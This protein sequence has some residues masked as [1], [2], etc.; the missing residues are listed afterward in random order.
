MTGDVSIVED[1]VDR[2]RRG[3]TPPWAWLILGAAAGCGIGVLTFGPNQ[4]PLS[5]ETG[6]APELTIEAPTDDDQA[7]G[8]GE[9]VDGFPD[10]LVAVVESEVAEFEH[11]MWPVQGEQI[12]RMLTNFSTGTATFDEYGRHM[13]VGAPAG[14]SEQWTLRVG[15]P[16]R[17]RDVASDVSGFAWHDGLPS[18][19]SYTK[20][21]DGRWQLWTFGM[22]KEP[23]LVSGD[24]PTGQ[25]AAWGD[26]GWVMQDGVSLTF[27]SPSGEVMT[28]RN[29]R[30]L[31]SAPDGTILIDDAGL[32]LVSADG[33]GFGT[34]LDVDHYGSIRAAELSPD[35]THIAL[36]DQA[37]LV[38]APLDGGEIVESPVAG[39]GPH[40]TWTSDSRF[41]V[42]AWFSGVLVI[43]MDEP[44]RPHTNLISGRAL[45]LATVP[46]S[47]R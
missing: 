7:G 4:A 46:L 22:A 26:W 39:G 23:E 6:P 18:V 1:G 37:K 24:G 20:E 34:E 30:V 43:D 38:V 42:S 8:I 5:E 13:A 15:R 3:P 14:V 35:G 10:T 45:T 28:R 27:L 33:R 44:G 25:I 40:L 9:V 47:R 36:L 29:G 16:T 17:F 19:L 2:S 32:Q 11:L 31:D 41:V 21:V 12:V